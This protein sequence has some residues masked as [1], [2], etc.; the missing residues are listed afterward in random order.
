MNG[1]FTQ[2]LEISLQASHGRFE[3]ERKREKRERRERE[4][5]RRE[6]KEEKR[7]RNDMVERSTKLCDH[8]V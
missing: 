3:R 6:R 5:E 1:G 4:R 7:E 8:Q 2:K